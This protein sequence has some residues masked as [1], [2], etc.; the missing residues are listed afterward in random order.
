MPAFGADLS[1]KDIAAIDKTI[2]DSNAAF[3]RSDAAAIGD[4]TSERL[5]EAV[6][7]RDKYVESIAAAIKA[8]NAQG[9]KVVSHTMVAPTPPIKAGNFIVTVVKEVTVME[10]RGRQMRND[11]FTVL[12]RPAAGGP[13]K[14][15]GGNGV[16]QNPGVVAMLYPGIPT[17]YKFPPY[18]TRPM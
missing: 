17:D 2:D 11:G 13:W 5:M 1:A 7:G 9:I 4:L 3:L 18:T 10:A 12:V 15:I 6:G 16:S 8:V 14:L